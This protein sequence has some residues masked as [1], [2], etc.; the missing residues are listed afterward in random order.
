MPVLVAKAQMPSAEQLPD[1]LKELAYRNCVELTHS[2]WDTDLQVLV[3]ALQRHIDDAPPEEARIPAKVDQAQDRAVEKNTL[4]A[5]S[6]GTGAL[7]TDR[8]RPATRSWRGLIV[9]AAAA[10][11]IAAG[12]GYASY[13]YRKASREE[14]AKVRQAAA[15]A[16][17]RQLAEDQETADREAN[18]KA[19][20][21]R[22]A[23]RKAAADR[24]GAP[25]AAADSPIIS[26]I[27]PA[28]G[29]AT[30]IV[31]ISG[32]GFS[33]VNRVMFNSRIAQ[34]NSQ[35]DTQLVV[36]VPVCAPARNIPFGIN[37]PVTVC[38]SAGCNSTP[39][40]FAYH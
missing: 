34:I 16:A 29:S 5:E 40:R 7:L 11:V 39:G 24:E 20:A 14:D 31:T 17:A 36:V 37:V 15:D 18:R 8:P 6:E 27:S 26:S 3:K 38:T 25:K 9:A 13:E 35:S 10:I 4:P 22:D 19:A 23:A 2:R 12:V 33:G 30:Q 1:D 32:S 21:D 28:T